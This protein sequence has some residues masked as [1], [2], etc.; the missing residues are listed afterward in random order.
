MQIHGVDHVEFYVGDAQQAAF[1]LCTAF[2]FRVSGQGGP[3]TGLEGARSLLLS[4]GGVRLLLTTGLD[5]RHPAT[6]YVRRHGDGVGVIAMG[7][8]DVQESFTTLTGRGAPALEEP[9]TLEA[10]G[11]TVRTAVVAGFGD[12]THR[13]VERHGNAEEFLPGLIDLIAPDVEEGEHLFSVVDHA[14]VLVPAGELGPTVDYYRDVFGF[15][16][17]FQEFIEVGDQAMDSKVVQ[18]ESGKVTFTIIE[19]VTSRRAGQIDDFLARHGGAGVQHLALLTDDIVSAV[20]TLEGRGVRFLKAPSSYYD[21]LEN[22]LGEP[23]L[24]TADLRETN[25]LVD[26]DH[27]GQVFQ[28]F[29]QS[30]HVR[31]TYFFEVIDRHGARTFGSGNVKALYEAVEREKANV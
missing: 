15:D 2:G 31:R 1:Y 12:V 28:I 16:N 17:I 4:Q 19:P 22:R 29:A 3:E 25:V 26:Q 6:E 11:A 14:A 9:R 20:Q 7:V 27:W 23:D 5:S 10:N 21:E 13:L 24:R 18:S 30:M 8:D